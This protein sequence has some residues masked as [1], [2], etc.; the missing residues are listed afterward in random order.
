MDHSQTLIEPQAIVIKN[1]KPI[2]NITIYVTIFID[3]QLTG[4]LA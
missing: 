1:M 4:S 3:A 2:H